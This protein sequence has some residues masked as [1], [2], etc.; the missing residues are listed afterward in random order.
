MR[1]T[2]VQTNPSLRKTGTQLTITLTARQKQILFK[3][4]KEMFLPL[5]EDYAAYAMWLAEQN[6]HYKSYKI[7]SIK[8]KE[9]K[10]T[11]KNREAFVN[12]PEQITHRRLLNEMMVGNIFKNVHD[13]ANQPSQA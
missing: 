10:V 13:L 5:L 1:Q 9:L 4:I 3:Q 12:S 2:K 11:I 6:D 8:E 7:K